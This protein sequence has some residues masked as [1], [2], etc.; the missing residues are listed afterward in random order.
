[1]SVYHC[2]ECGALN[3]G[4]GPR[5]TGCVDYMVSL[6]RLPKEPVPTVDTIAARPA[7]DDGTG[8]IR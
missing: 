1:M 5:C 6:G 4:V 3:E 2:L 7:R 8:A